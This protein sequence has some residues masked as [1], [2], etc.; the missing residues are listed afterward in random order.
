VVGEGGLDSSGSEKGPVAGISE[1]G[2]EPSD[3]A[4]IKKQKFLDLLSVLPAHN[5]T[6]LV[7]HA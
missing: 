5:V 6:A 1:H 3:Y 7:H 4:R 2:N